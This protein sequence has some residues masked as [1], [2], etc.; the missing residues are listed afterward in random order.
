MRP[1]L[2][3]LLAFLLQAPAYGGVACAPGFAQFLGKFERREIDQAKHTK[4][5]LR[6]SHPDRDDLERGPKRL[7]LDQRSAEK[8]ESFPTVETQARLKV[9][10]HIS[11]DKSGNCEVKFQVPDSDMYAITFTFASWNGTWRLVAIED[12]SL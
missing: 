4:F 3:I 12:F 8:F 9:E 7:L 10:R 6:Y 11:K 2:F 5:P 1:S